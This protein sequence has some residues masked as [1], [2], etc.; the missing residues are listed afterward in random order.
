MDDR[1][2]LKRL[3][4]LIAGKAEEPE[5]EMSGKFS[6]KRFY[7]ELNI[8]QDERPL[9]DEAMGKGLEKY[10]SDLYGYDKY[11][12]E[13][14]FL[15][16][17]RMGEPYIF[18][19]AA[20][21]ILHHE[22]I[23]ART[24]RA[25]A[26]YTLAITRPGGEFGT[27]HGLSVAVSYLVAGGH[28]RGQQLAS[29][30][31]SLAGEQDVFVSMT[32]EDTRALTDGLIADQELSL[33][34]RLDLLNFLLIRCQYAFARGKE[35]LERALETPAISREQKKTLCTWIIHGRAQGRQ[36]GLNV[37][38]ALMRGE[39]AGAF[40]QLTAASLGLVPEYL[41][42]HAIVGLAQV[43]GDPAAVARRYLGAGKRY[44]AV[45]FDQAVGDIIETY[46]AEMSPAEVREMVEQGARASAFQTRLR[47]YQLGLKL[48]GPQFI[49]PALEDRSKK[50]QKWARK[51][52]KEK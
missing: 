49:R 41:K 42:R 19:Y 44:D 20:V 11:G 16:D 36:E 4:R 50:V 51:Q 10:Y 35:M 8:S 5:D 26:E 12:K 6:L 2:S 29:A 13:P 46:H 22:G 45:P 14:V 28:L 39:E 3:R 40:P 47:F 21:R 23:S 24:K 52:L 15:I 34:E 18:G 1:F 38:E 7:K 17:E 25:V 31:R 43:E 30:V 33:E 48:Y 9:I 37:L 32:A 27:P